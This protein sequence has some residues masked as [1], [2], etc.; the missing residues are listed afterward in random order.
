[1]FLLCQGQPKMII[2]NY[3]K[4]FEYRI[5]T[6]FYNAFSPTRYLFYCVSPGL[7]QHGVSNF[8]P[9]I[10]RPYYFVADKNSVQNKEPDWKKN[11]N[12]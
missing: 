9:I 8:Y 1:M 12:N 6:G 3:F 5:F 10:T 11:S 2:K 7:F 4:F